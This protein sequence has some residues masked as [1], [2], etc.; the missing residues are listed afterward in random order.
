MFGDVSKLVEIYDIELQS[1]AK[2]FK[3][4]VECINIERDI[5]TQL[6]N[7]QIRKL[8][9]VQPKLRRIRFSEEDSKAKLLPVQI[10]LGISDYNKL[11]IQSAPIIGRYPDYPVAE[12]TK[13]GWILSGGK[14]IGSAR[15]FCHLTMTGQEQFEKLCRIDVLGI[16]D[17]PETDFKHE[18]FKDQIKLGNGHYSTKLPWRVNHEE[19]PDN[20]ALSQARLGSTTRKLNKMGQLE[21][22]HQIMM[23]QLETG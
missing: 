17:Q 15:E 14:T 21:A 5:I 9:K 20:K 1:K 12:Q 10:L 8:K 23:E 3:I 16:K 2:D 19:L 18:D 7:P 4:K 11:R 6:P 22:Y 13:L